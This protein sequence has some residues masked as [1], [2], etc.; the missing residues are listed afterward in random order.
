MVIGSLAGVGSYRKSYGNWPWAGSPDR[1][2]W[3]GRRYYLQ[4]TVTPLPGRYDP[5][6]VIFRAPAVIGRQVLSDRTRA[7]IEREQP[8]AERIGGAC[9]V[10]L[11]RRTG[12]T[13]FK[14]YVLSGSP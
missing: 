11:Y 8:A 13:Q 6:T 12:G 10:F 1:L 7:Q 14:L 2:D 5:R 9:G 3:C 4:D